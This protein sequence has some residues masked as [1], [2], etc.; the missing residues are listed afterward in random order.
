M[1]IETK[2]RLE[3]LRENEDG[4]YTYWVVDWVE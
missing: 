2:Q 1:K 4:T 3:E